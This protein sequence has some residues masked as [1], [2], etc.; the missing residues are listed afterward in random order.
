MNNLSREE[1][2]Q[3]LVD[4]EIEISNYGYEYCGID[5]DDEMKELTEQNM[6]IGV[7]VLTDDELEVFLNDRKVKL[8]ETKVKFRITK[9]C[10]IDL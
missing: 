8:I 5:F 6:R 1:M 9:E 10:G 7:E 4:I 2:V 3:K